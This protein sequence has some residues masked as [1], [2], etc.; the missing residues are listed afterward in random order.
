MHSV[1]YRSMIKGDYSSSLDKS[2]IDKMI[3]ENNLRDGG[4]CW[5]Y[6]KYKLENESVN[7]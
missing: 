5:L 3:F 7:N 6:T 2:C 4:C 1:N